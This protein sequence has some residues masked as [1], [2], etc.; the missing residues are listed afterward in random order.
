MESF[1]ALL[2]TLIRALSTQ[3]IDIYRQ[4]CRCGEHRDLIA[5]DF[6]EATSDSYELLL[7]T[8][9]LHTHRVRY[10][11]RDE[12]CM[13]RQ[14]AKLPARRTDDKHRDV[15]FIYLFVRRY[16]FQLDG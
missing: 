8:R 5:L 10:E 9:E 4:L 2:S 12:R 15:C 3:H 1:Q 7:S 16:N 13:L 14:Y 6:H 11:P